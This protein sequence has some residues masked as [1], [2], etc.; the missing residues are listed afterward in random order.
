MEW[1]YG[2]EFVPNGNHRLR[3]GITSGMS[4][5]HT[6]IAHCGSAAIGNALPNLLGTHG[7][8]NIGIREPLHHP[9]EL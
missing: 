7:N 5:F 9:G 6:G 1:E 4:I 8:C 2:Q 3:N